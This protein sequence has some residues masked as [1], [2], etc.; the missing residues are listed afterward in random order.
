MLF[1]ILA[2][3]ISVHVC[4]AAKDQAPFH[5]KSNH[6]SYF[7][8]GDI[9]LGRYQSPYHEQSREQA[10]FAERKRVELGVVE[11]VEQRLRFLRHPYGQYTGFHCKSSIA[12]HYL[13]LI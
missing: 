13:K 9:D 5:G 11:C 6:C 8:A 1:P 7:M 3:S 12:R 2:A 4:F 10:Y